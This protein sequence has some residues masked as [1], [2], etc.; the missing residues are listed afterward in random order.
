M[1]SPP[2]HPVAG[3]VRYIKRVHVVLAGIAGVEGNMILLDSSSVV[4][5]SALAQ[6]SEYILARM[7]IRNSAMI[8]RAI[9]SVYANKIL[10]VKA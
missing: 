6:D 8:A 3:L 9:W 7:R 2:W 10:I 5:L 1:V 4:N